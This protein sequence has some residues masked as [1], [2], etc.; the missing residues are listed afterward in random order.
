MYLICGFITINAAV[1]YYV[2]G[3]ITFMD[4]ITLAGNQCQDCGLK[5]S[6]SQMSL[7]EVSEV[8]KKLLSGKVKGVDVI[9]PEMLK[10]PDS[11]GLSGVCFMY[12]EK[13]YDPVFGES[14]AHIL[15]THF[16]GMV[17]SARLHIVRI[18]FMICTQGTQSM[19]F[20][21]DDVVLLVC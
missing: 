20:F 13:T 9:H 3:F 11:F 21:A 2:C 5:I 1:F 4:I 16:Q 19:V 10:D 14:N 6:L 18:L 8:V 15:G 17:A 12:L 7:A